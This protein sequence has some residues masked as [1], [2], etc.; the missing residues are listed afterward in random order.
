MF[1]HRE[2]TT[3]NVNAST[4]EEPAGLLCSSVGCGGLSSLCASVMDG[5]ILERGHLDVATSHLLAAASYALMGIK[6]I[7]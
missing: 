5:L 2:P 4:C 6:N 1:H 3:S 7:D